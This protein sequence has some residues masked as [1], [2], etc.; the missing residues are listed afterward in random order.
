FGVSRRS[1]G[2]YVRQAAT[3]G[4][5]APRR[6]PGR[7]RH[8]PV[9]QDAQLTAQLRAHPTAT[10]ERQCQ[11]WAETTDRRVSVTT[12][13]RAMRRLGWSWKKSG[14]GHRAG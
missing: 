14:G 8:I 4:D 11:L 12:I 10:V 9:E 13:Y 7:Q 2:R 6:H 5:L 3:T 1:I